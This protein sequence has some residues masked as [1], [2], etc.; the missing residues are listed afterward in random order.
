VETSRLETFSD[1]VFAIAITLLILE[2]RLP[3]EET[4]SLAH[5]LAEAWPGYVSYVISFVTIGIMWANH[6]GVFRL[7]DRTSHGLVVANLFL[8]LCVA[9]I[10]F[11]TKVL[12][13]HLSGAGD[14]QRAVTV[15]YC[16]TFTVTAAFYNLLWQ[17]AAWRNRLIASGAE[18]GAAEVTRRY[19]YGVPSYLAATV[20]ALWS[21][22]VSLA[23]DAGLALL[24]VLPR[25][26]VREPAR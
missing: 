1:G 25:R 10:P 4:G 17:T 3:P 2:V 8:L 22:P 21:V 23:I 5:R 13:E 9:F 19:R 16:G 12:G 18:A 14:V 24:Y 20:A 6:H 7:I 26:E 15:F 11:P